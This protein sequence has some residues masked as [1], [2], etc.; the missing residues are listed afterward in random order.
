VTGKK[1]PLQEERSNKKRREEMEAAFVEAKATP[2]PP[3]NV[4]LAHEQVAFDERRE[5]RLPRKAT[6]GDWNGT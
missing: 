2:P 5:A 4:S 6:K 3:A 1:P